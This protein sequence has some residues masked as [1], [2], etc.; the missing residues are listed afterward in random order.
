MKEIRNSETGVNRFDLTV[1]ESRTDA[2][3]DASTAGGG[4]VSTSCI[5]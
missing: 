5:D 3:A 2:S 1:N 4:V